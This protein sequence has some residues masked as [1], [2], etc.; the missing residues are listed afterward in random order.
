M[1]WSISTTS[2]D[3]SAAVKV[4]LKTLSLAANDR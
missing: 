3:A 2:A 1:A 4:S